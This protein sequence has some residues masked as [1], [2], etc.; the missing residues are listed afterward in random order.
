MSVNRNVHVPDR[1]P[2]TPHPPPAAPRQS[3]TLTRALVPDGATADHD[4]LDDSHRGQPQVP[5]EA[6]CG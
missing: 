4:P 2:V 1:R 5:L 3:P 6:N